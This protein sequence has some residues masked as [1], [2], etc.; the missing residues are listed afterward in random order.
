MSGSVPDVKQKRKEW[1]DCISRYKNSELVFLD[2]SGCNTD[3]TRR[4]ARSVGGSRAVDAV[5]LNTPTNTTILSTIQLD[6]KAWY[7][8]FCGGT[9]A[10]RFLD[11]LEQVLLPHLD[12]NAVLIMDNMPSHRAKPVRELLDRENIRYIYLPPYSPDLNPIEKM[13]SKIKAILRKYKV[14]SAATL[15][16]AIDRAFACISSTDC[17][18]WF[19]SCGY[20][21]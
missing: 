2:E 1:P 18:G 20:V 5:P 6:G 13:W 4:Y 7:T 14:R 15:P 10:V 8:T 3:M 12:R 19:T 16:D 21:Q 17:M 11:Y 9:T